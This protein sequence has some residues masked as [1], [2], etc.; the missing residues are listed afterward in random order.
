[1]YGECIVGTTVFTGLRSHTI[2]RINSLTLWDPS[3]FLKVIFTLYNSS[4]YPSFCSGG[5][6]G[7][8]L[9]P[10]VISAILNR[11]VTVTTPTN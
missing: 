6:L 8:K 4:T 3:F 5:L 9:L 2:V 11:Y 1:M 10:E 7:S